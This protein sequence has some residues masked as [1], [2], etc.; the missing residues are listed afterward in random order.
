V[1]GEGP[2]LVS[3]VPYLTR[4][5]PREK[6]SSD[7]HLE[8]RPESIR[9]P[10]TAMR[11]SLP[12]LGRALMGASSPAVN[13]LID[14][15]IAEGLDILN[16]SQKLS[17][18]AQVTES[19]LACTTQFEFQ[20]DK[21]VFARMLTRPD[22][23]DAPPAAFW[24][25][26]G[27]TDTALFGRG[28][29]AK[30]FERPRALIANLLLEATDSAGMP[31]AE[32]KLVKELVADRMLALFTNGEG[33]YA[34]GFDQAA[35][36][37][38]RRGVQSVRPGDTSGSAEAKRVLL[39]QV[40]GW[41]LYQVNEPVATVGPLLKDWSA[42][43]NRPAFSKWAQ[44][45]A[46]PG[47]LPRMR[48]LPSPAGVTLP[49]ESVH[50]E[51]TIPREDIELAPPP[52]PPGARQNDG[53]AKAPTAKP[54]KIARKALL[55]HVLAVPDGGATW[56]GFGFDARLVAEKAASSLAGAPDARTLGKIVAGHE[57]LREGKSN[58][59]GLATLRGVI[60]FAALDAHDERSPFS[61]LSTLPGK[62]ATPV[63]FTGR[64]EGPSAN[65]KA[66]GSAFAV[67]LPRT[68][69]EDVVKL[70]MTSR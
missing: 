60:V 31:E 58:A 66:G 23:A 9:G 12:L 3:L 39:E 17:L 25:L 51:I 30:L 22:R 24:H 44:A 2:A 67:R 5:M 43:W 4:T 14:S 13:D 16:D 42:L 26:P 32:R 48:L 50:L 68:V 15:V 45:K 62:G 69:I 11:A 57:L 19:G 61:L 46:T 33:I 27:D 47:L 1:C 37:K 55:F 21:S 56:L 49:K 41:H 36:D 54:R 65:A 18:D 70:I 29:D 7:I 40:V 38:A 52:P 8:L 10:L 53:R 63:V 34:K 59:G 35:V 6:W 64:A 28:S 20:S